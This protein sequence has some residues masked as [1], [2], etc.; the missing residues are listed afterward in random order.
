MVDSIS[1]DLENLILV[2]MFLKEKKYELGVNCFG[3][4]LL[5]D[6]DENVKETNKKIDKLIP[7]C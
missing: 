7:P 4:H 2:H 6:G 1:K 5:S 3:I